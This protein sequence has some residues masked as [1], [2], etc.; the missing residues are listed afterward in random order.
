MDLYEFKQ[1]E[2]RDGWLIEDDEPAASKKP[3]RERSVELIREGW[4][5][6]QASD[7]MRQYRRPVVR[8]GLV[9]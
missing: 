8:D 9:G 2:I 5:P 6:V 4:E 7:V 1:L 3:L